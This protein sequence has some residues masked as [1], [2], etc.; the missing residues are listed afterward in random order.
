[1][2]WLLCEVTWGRELNDKASTTQR[3]GGSV[4]QIRG[5]SW[6]KVPKAGEPGWHGSQGD[7][8][9]THGEGPCERG[10]SSGFILSPWKVVSG[11][12]PVTSLKAHLVSGA[13]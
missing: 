8:R 9:V 7:L 2:G 5:S 1:M 6:Y 10:R 13:E 11:R 4:W 12:V 3:S